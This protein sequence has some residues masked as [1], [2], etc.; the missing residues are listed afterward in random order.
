MCDLNS[1]ANQYSRVSTSNPL[2]LSNPLVNGQQLAA[3]GIFGEIIPKNLHLTVKLLL[4]GMISIVIGTVLISCNSSSGNQDNSA[5]PS[6]EYKV[7]NY[8][9]S[10]SYL[11]HCAFPRTGVHPFTNRPFPDMQGSVVLE[12]HQLRSWA[13]EDYLWYDELPDLD[14]NNYDNPRDYFALLK[15]SELT[16]NGTAKD[17]FH[18]TE[19]E[20]AGDQVTFT[21]TRGGYG[22]S[23][24]FGGGRQVFVSYVVDNTPAGDAGVT[25][26]MLIKSVNGVAVAE[27][28]N[29]QLPDLNTAIFAPVLGDISTFEFITVAGATITVDLAAEQVPISA[30][31]KHSILDTASGT[32]G[33]IAF[34]TFNTF[35][36]EDQLKAAF[37]D[38]ASNGIDDLVVDLRYNGGGYIYI[39]SQ[40]AYL[41]AGD[42]KTDGNT[43]TVLRY[44]DK[45]L[46]SNVRYSFLANTSNNAS[47][48]NRFLPLSS[49]NLNRVYVLTTGNTCSASE[50][51]INGLRG[52]GVEVIQIGSTTCGKPHGFNARVNCGTRYFSI[53]FESVNGQE[54]GDYVDG[55]E[56]V[57]TGGDPLSNK[58]NGCPASDDLAYELGDS[59]EE[60]L[61]TALYYRANGNCPSAT[62]GAQKPRPSLRVDGEFVAPPA[63]KVMRVAP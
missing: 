50:S 39:A 47:I 9:P 21:G 61:S 60:M 33:Y 19:D 28:T 14:P 45:R 62:T 41:V 15:T 13:H 7:G 29:E 2:N 22:I 37:D 16:A 25:R 36:A 46:N 48:E 57:A 6:S 34:N 3:Y 38:F 30:V 53:D 31:L 23:W 26:G 35:T 49:V 51:F 32:V 54:F 10:P 42:D 5:T 12:N 52:V 1:T 44:N 27:A 11:N 63:D 40:L 59:N 20:I 18:F 17:R 55:F 8:Q 24:K 58:I 56:P 4:Q 43:F